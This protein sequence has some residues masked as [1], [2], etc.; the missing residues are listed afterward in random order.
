MRL[1]SKAYRDAVWPPR[2]LDAQFAHV[3]VTR[4]GTA[5]GV[6]VGQDRAVFGKEFDD[7]TDGDLF[8]VRQAGEPVG[9]LVGALDVP[10][11][12]SSMPQEALCVT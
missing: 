5:R 2:H 12:D 10:R 8:V 9:K 6:R 7:A 11:H 1:G 4:R 3:A